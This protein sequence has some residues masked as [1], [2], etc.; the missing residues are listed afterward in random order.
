MPGT[1]MLHS[2]THETQA[3]VKLFDNVHKDHVTLEYL[4][5]FDS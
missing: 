3:L 2:C 4:Q 5:F 1:T